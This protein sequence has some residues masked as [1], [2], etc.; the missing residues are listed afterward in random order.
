MN[1]TLVDDTLYIDGN[2]A[3]SLTHALTNFPAQSDALWGVMATKVAG[4]GLLETELIRVKGELADLTADNE[5]LR[6]EA[7]LVPGLQA[8]LETLSAASPCFNPRVI[9]PSEFRA[10]FTDEQLTAIA[11]SAMA[12]PTLFVFLMH[13]FT[14]SSVNLDS[15]KTIAGLNYLAAA[16]IGID[17]VQ[18]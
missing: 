17:G 6:R 15:D 5:K 2:D 11:T 10:R 13:L 3:G 16:G 8:E 1:I 4:V 14:E 7:A 18:F 9:S 12:D